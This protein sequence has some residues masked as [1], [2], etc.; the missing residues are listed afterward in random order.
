[1][2]VALPGNLTSKQFNY[3]W[4]ATTGNN[5]IFASARKTIKYNITWPEAYSRCMGRY[6]ICG[7]IAFDVWMRIAFHVPMSQRCIWCTVKNCIWCTGDYWIWCTYGAFDVWLSIVFYV[8]VGIAFDLWLN[9]AFDVRLS[10]AFDVW[11]S[12][13]LNALESIA[14]DAWIFHP[15]LFNNVWSDSLVTYSRDIWMLLTFQ[16]CK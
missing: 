4:N 16:I 12:I 1:M 15:K 8:R 3:R 5:Y 2:T 10:I 14:L 6:R 13:A 7:W 11:M 9:I